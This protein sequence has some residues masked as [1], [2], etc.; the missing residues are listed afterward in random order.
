MSGPVRRCD[1]RHIAVWQVI[2]LPCPTGRR[3]EPAGSSEAT[4][5]DS[6]RS[7]VLRLVVR[8]GSNCRPSA[9][10]DSVGNHAADPDLW[11]FCGA[12]TRSSIRSPGH[13]EH[14]GNA[15]GAARRAGPD[16]DASSSA[17]ATSRGTMMPS[18][19]TA[20]RPSRYRRH[21]RHLNERQ[22]RS[23]HR[24]PAHPGQAPAT[25]PADASQHPDHPLPPP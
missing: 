20:T 10:Q 22:P 1:V 19:A 4:R 24:C 3:K 14:P 5:R 16:R 17:A 21:A 13:Q 8:A 9:F 7:A 6:R 18:Q 2:I 15:N 23:P 12:T 25:G 11:G